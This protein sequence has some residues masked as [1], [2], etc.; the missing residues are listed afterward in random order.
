MQVSNLN[1]N[2]AFYLNPTDIERFKTLNLTL[3]S[4]LRLGTIPGSDIKELFIYPD[5]NSKNHIREQKHSKPHPWTFS[6]WKS[7]LKKE[8]T[9]TECQYDIKTNGIVIFLPETLTVKSRRITKPIESPN[10]FE[11]KVTLDEFSEAVK[12]V[13]KFLIQNQ[14]L[15]TLDIQNGIFLRYLI[16]NS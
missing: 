16:S 3:G 8:F 1:D 11:T 12:K 2:L 9:T 6:F 7:G 14:N 4:T 10:T 13:N 5:R 15:V